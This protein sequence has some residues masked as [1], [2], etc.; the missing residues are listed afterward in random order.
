M[1]FGVWGSR[2]A[3][4][5]ASV[6]TPTLVG[7]RGGVC[8]RGWAWGDVPQAPSLPPRLMEGFWQAFED[9][10]V[11]LRCREVVEA[12][13]LGMERIGQHGFPCGLWHIPPRRLEAAVLRQPPAGPADQALEGGLCLGLLSQLQ[14]RRVGPAL[15]PL[16][17]KH[18]V[19]LDGGVD[20]AVCRSVMGTGGGGG[21]GGV[22]V[23]LCC[24]GGRGAGAW[25]YA[26][27]W[28]RAHG[29]CFGAGLEPMGAAVARHLLDMGR[30]RG[31]VTGR[32]R[33]WLALA[34]LQSGRVWSVGLQCGL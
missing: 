1:L 6:C 32:G 23:V 14:E 19:A 12:D 27:L 16:F 18:V 34:L 22:L 2:G 13:F 28:V 33:C 15:P 10:G 8:E 17:M 30:H 21:P 26:D 11:V 24:G 7:S 4:G 20:V 5:A 9:I 25:A 3:A 29:H 31:L